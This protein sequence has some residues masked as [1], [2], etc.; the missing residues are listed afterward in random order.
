MDR[1][2]G[3]Q[4]VKDPSEKSQNAREGKEDSA[5]HSMHT[6]VYDQG[7]TWEFIP[8]LRSITRLPILLKGIL[9]PE[10]A[11]IAVHRW[12]QCQKPPL[13]NRRAVP[14]PQGHPGS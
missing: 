13:R 12:V 4:P 9:S 14:S 7:L 2:K 10:D 3:V 11:Y 1:V 8:W 5:Y 6:S